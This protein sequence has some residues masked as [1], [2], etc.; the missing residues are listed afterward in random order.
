M[1]S[2]PMSACRLTHWSIAFLTSAPSSFSSKGWAATFYLRLDQL[3]QIGRTGQAADMRGENSIGAG[4]HG[5]SSRD[6][7]VD[8]RGRSAPVCHVRNREALA[9]ALNL[10]AGKVRLGEFRDFHRTCVGEH[11]GGN[12]I[13]DVL[14]Q[15]RM[16]LALVSTLDRDAQG[17]GVDRRAALAADDDVQFCLF[18]AVTER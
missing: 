6:L 17:P 14:R 9:A 16:R 18:D 11:I 10:H 8:R 13:R 5:S 12:V 7:T 2:R 15:R 1:T 3:E 4:F